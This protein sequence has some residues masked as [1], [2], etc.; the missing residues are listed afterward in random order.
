M[1]KKQ[2][3]ASSAR[4]AQAHWRARWS[5]LVEEQAQSGLSQPQF[6]EA[7]GLDLRAFRRWKYRN[8]AGRKRKGQRLSSAKFV[9][10]EV[11]ATEPRL[12]RLEI[13]SDSGV[14]VHL[15]GLSV[16]VSV[17]FDQETFR[18]VLAALERS[19]C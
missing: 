16:R 3:L 2:A 18:Q 15:G 6:C 10:V 19:G 7:R 9:P 12:P 5:E 11:E 17:G 1:R 14:A 4:K 8:L 13:E